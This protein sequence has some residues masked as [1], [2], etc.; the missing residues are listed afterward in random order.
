VA[1]PFEIN[2]KMSP[3]AFP[4]PIGVGCDICS[5]SRIGNLIQE[6]TRFTLFARRLFTQLEWPSLVQKIKK[7]G[8]ENIRENHDYKQRR[9]QK[10]AILHLPKISR[11]KLTGREAS[12]EGDLVRYL[13][14]RYDRISS[15]KSRHRRLSY[16]MQMGSQGGRYQGAS[17][18]PIAHE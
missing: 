18:P 2:M 15:A 4:F 11:S 5:I 6:P 17:P 7:T 13:A 14:G 10:L 12:P 3:K 1:Y 9:T 8:V 16:H